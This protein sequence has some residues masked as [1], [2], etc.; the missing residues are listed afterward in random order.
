MGPKVFFL[1]SALCGS[2]L[3]FAYFLVPETKGL[4][5]E[6]ADK[7]LEET[8]PA[9]PPNGSHTAPSPKKW[10]SP[11][12]VSHW[13]ADPLPGQ[14]LSCKK[15]R[16]GFRDIVASHHF[17]ICLIMVLQ[18]ERWLTWLSLQVLDRY[19]GGVFSVHRILSGRSTDRI[20]AHGRIS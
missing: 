20:S 13:S 18:H 17:G 16:F 5:L 1:W 6:Q 3:S 15:S 4:S 9:H 10:V 11:R 8:T 19:W 12:R 7:M 2:S 14:R